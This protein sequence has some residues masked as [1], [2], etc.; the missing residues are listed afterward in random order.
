MEGNFGKVLQGTVLLS[1]QSCL[2]QGGALVCSLLV[3]LAILTK[4]GCMSHGFLKVRPEDRGL[5]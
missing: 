3:S 5:I 2:D 1:L 4:G